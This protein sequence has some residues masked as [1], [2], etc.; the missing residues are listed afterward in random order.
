MSGDITT[1]TVDV[2]EL[3]CFTEISYIVYNFFDI[4]HLMYKGEMNCICP[5]KN[6]FLGLGIYAKR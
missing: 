4:T 2:K 5:M 1:K 6:G 3:A